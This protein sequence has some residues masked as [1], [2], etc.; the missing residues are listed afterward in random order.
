MAG[1]NSLANL[2]LKIVLLT[3]VYLIEKYQIRCTTVYYFVQELDSQGLNNLG[4]KYL[5]P[6]VHFIV[7]FAQYK[8]V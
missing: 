3:K 2:Y 4:T 7:D 6:L 5:C 1:L 8:C